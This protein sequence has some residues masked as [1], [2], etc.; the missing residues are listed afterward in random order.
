MILSKGA[1]FGSKGIKIYYKT[2]SNGILSNLGLETALKRFHYWV[3]SC[4]ERISTECSYK[5]EWDTQ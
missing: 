4:F 1:I 2:R 5:Y 3:I